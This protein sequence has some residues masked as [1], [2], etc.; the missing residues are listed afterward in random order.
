[1]MTQFLSDSPIVVFDLD[2]TLY[3]EIDY[4][5]SAYHEIAGYLC[6]GGHVPDDPF[7]RM[8]GW[9][10][11][12]RNVFQSLNDYY[13]LDIPIV[14][15]LALYRNHVPNIALD[16]EVEQTLSEL[17]RDGCVL[18]LISDG[19]SITQRN[20]IA[21]LG[22]DRFVRDDCIIISEEIGS[23]KPDA[24]NYLAIQQKFP[25]RRFFYVGDN[26]QKDFIA[27]NSLKWMTI[28]VLDDGRNIHKQDFSLEKQFLPRAIVSTID[29]IAQY[30]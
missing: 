24:L 21:A 7:P 13:G 29:Q 1:M 8:L 3:K 15:L 28:C 19:R 20:K 6:A 16:P 27:P 9:Y 10:R 11:Q 5:Y 23:E 14:S 25:G 4:L 2:D 22:L 12:G 30:L 26:P 18:G 17:C